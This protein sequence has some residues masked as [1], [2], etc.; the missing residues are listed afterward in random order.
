M[1]FSSGHRAEQYTRMDSTWHSVGFRCLYHRPRVY[2]P[3]PVAA[4]FPYAFLRIYGIY[5][6]CKLSPHFWKYLD[7]WFLQALWARSTG[8]VWLAIIACLMFPRSVIF[9]STDDWPLNLMQACLRDTK[10]QPHGP[11]SPCHD[12][13][14]CYPHV[15]SRVLFLWFPV[16]SLDVSRFFSFLNGLFSNSLSL[17]RNGAGYVSRLSLPRLL[18][19][20]SDPY[21]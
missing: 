4:Y 7:L 3:S 9:V 12:H 17:S 8:M 19:K 15:D 2:C 1:E 13:A 16:C 11:L 5:H 18:C 14:I 20:L 10:K 21:V 6:D